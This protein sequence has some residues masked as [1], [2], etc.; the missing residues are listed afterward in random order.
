MLWASGLVAVFPSPDFADKL[1]S[2]SPPCQEGRGPHDNLRLH[3]GRV[4]TFF[5]VLWFRL[6]D[7]VC[8]EY[9]TCSI[10]YCACR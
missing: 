9:V 6:T 4:L 10:N 8:G 7:F 5:N 2:L 1:Q 3:S